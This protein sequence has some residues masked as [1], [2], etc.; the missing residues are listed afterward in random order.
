LIVRLPSNH[1]KGRII[2]AGMLLL[3]LF[4]CH[5]EESTQL[6]DPQSAALEFDNTPLVYESFDSLATDLPGFFVEKER[7]I[8]SNLVIEG[9]EF[10]APGVHHL[11][12]FA[13]ARFFDWTHPIVMGNDTI[14]FV[15]TGAGT[16]T[17]D[18]LPL[19]LMPRRVFSPGDSSQSGGVQY[20]LYDDDG[21]GGRG[22]Q[23]FGGHDYLWTISG[24]I[25][26]PAAEFTVFAPPVLHV[27]SPDLDGSIT[28]N[29]DFVA[30]WTGGGDVI[31]FVFSTVSPG[32]RPRPVLQ[33]RVGINRGRV[34]IPSRIMQLLPG[35]QPR[36]LFTVASRSASV[37]SINGV[38][39]D[40]SLQT[41]T[42]HSLLLKVIP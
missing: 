6:T 5:Q 38:A 24:S 23:Y 19:L 9:S 12:A 8:S 33:L 39:A 13:Q 29:R 10:D 41:E 17:L 35:S 25:N 37:L 32:Q 3:P 14:D 20:Q 22:F 16:V 30:E 7:V 34:K 40:A 11:S 15:T 26:V 1:I 27:I 21:T 31:R 4:G 2:V 28:L 18:D 36:L 42:S